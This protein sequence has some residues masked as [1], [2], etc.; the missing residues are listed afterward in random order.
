MHKSYGGHMNKY[1]VTITFKTK[2]GKPTTLKFNE[3]ADY[4]EEAKNNALDQL[5]KNEPTLHEILDVWAEC[6]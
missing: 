5:R 6:L 2:K 4:L 1:R 3:W